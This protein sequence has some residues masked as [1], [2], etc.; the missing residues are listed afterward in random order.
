MS[1]ISRYLEKAERYLQRGKPESAL[2]EYLSALDIDP[3]NEAVRQNAADVALSLGRTYEAILHLEWPFNHLY[4]KGE[5]AKALANFRKLAKI[6]EPSPEQNFRC[7]ELT[8]QTNRKAAQE[9]YEKALAGFDAAGHSENSLECLKHIVE[10]EPSLENLNRAGELASTLQQ[11]MLAAAYFRAAGQMEIQEGGAGLA[12]LGRAYHLDKS[13]EAGAYL[14]A[15]SLLT[16]G[17]PDTAAKVIGVFAQFPEADANTRSLYAQALLQANHPDEAYPLLWNEFQ[18]DP[19]KEADLINLIDCF[20]VHDNPEMALNVAHNL[21]PWEQ[22]QGRVREFAA[23]LQRV[24]EQHP[25]NADILEFLC[26]LFNN[27]SMEHEYCET[28]LHVY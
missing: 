10:L 26:D 22:R 13:N 7:A 11:E 3:A 23:N 25:P 24:T 8:E 1:D 15:H 28:L 20:L 17:E 4:S 19:S 18:T 14:Y 5:S 6:T 16:N 21:L 9:L 27:C 2:E 12:S